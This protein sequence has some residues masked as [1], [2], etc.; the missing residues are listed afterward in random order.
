MQKYVI[1]A[2]SGL[3]QK[4]KKKTLSD[5]LPEAIAAGEQVKCTITLITSQISRGWGIVGSIWDNLSSQ[6]N[7]CIRF[8]TF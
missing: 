4:K 2:S 6:L 5:S 8:L 1:S 3:E 7:R